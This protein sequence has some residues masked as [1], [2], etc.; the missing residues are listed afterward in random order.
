MMRSLGRSETRRGARSL[1]L[2]QARV[3][4]ARNTRREKSDAPR[5]R[6]LCL[7]KR[8]EVFQAIT[9]NHVIATP[10]TSALIARRSEVFP[11]E[12][13]VR[14]YITGSTDTSLWT[15]YKAGARTYC[16][17]SFPDG[18]K[19][20]AKLEARSGGGARRDARELLSGRH[21]RMSRARLD[22]GRA[23]KEARLFFCGDRPTQRSEAYILEGRGRAGDR[24]K[25]NGKTPL[26]LLLP[27]ARWRC[28]RRRRRTRCTTR[29]S[30]RRRSSRAGA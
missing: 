6:A 27:R 21:V 26:V 2:C 28:A 18:M 14:G 25:E 4:R 1:S 22:L 29:R 8:G 10:H 7:S 3:L 24:R 17:H 13:V 19:K 15:H 12:F 9:P 5:E 20:N 11:V 23:A 30:H 16:G